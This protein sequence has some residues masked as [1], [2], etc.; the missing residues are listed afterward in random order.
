MVWTCP[1]CKRSGWPVG[2]P[3]LALQC[4]IARCSVTTQQQLKC[5][6]MKAQ[7][8]SFLVAPATSAVG[9]Q[10]LPFVSVLFAVFSSSGHKKTAL[11]ELVI[12][13][14]RVSQILVTWKC[15]HVSGTTKETREYCSKSKHEGDGAIF[16]NMQL[17]NYSMN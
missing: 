12:H 4:V 3:S 1:R 13:I 10:C 6:R 2:L 8:R 11:F 15:E 16:I 7:Q 14:K 5:G 17:L 9:G